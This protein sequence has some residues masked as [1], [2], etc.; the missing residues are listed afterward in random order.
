MKLRWFE[1]FIKYFFSTKGECTC[2][3]T[4]NQGVRGGKIIDLKKTVDTAV[5]N[6]PS[7]SKVF[8]WKRTDT[9][10][11]FDSKDVIIDEV[12]LFFYFKKYITDILI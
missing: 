6:C 2:V 5:K 12:S 9:L 10:T 1:K 8:I 3:I 4:A 11:S 7:V